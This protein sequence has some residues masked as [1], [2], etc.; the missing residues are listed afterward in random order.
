[1]YVDAFA[2]T[3]YCGKG[4]AKAPECSAELFSDYQEE[5]AQRYI[6]GSARIALETK[7]EFGRYIYVDLDQHNCAKL[8]ELREEYPSKK[9]RITIINSDANAYLADFVR[10]TDWRNKR[11]VLFLD[12]FGMEVRWDTLRAI[13]SSRAIDAWY[14][15]PISAVNRMLARSGDLPSAWIKRLDALFG[16]SDWRD[17][18]YTTEDGTDLFGKT[19][20]VRKTATWEGITRYI[21]GR[22]KK[23]FPEVVEEPRYLKNPHNNTPLYLMC[24]VA[25]CPG[26][27]GQLAVKL[28]RGVLESMD[29]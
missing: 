3:G 19:S 8:Q 15:F 27:G 6:S 7:P 22:L 16:V 25:A 9:D 26:R 28:A 29:K 21:I 1:M 23:E 4:Q 11:T 5:A 12:P 17:S 20:R 2:G 18:F 24:F 13:A 10:S 14:L